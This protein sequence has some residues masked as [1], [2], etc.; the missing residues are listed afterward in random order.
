MNKATEELLNDLKKFRQLEDYLRVNQQELTQI[1]L[2][3]HLELLLRTCQ[4]SKAEVIARANLQESYGYQI[5]SG[6]KKPSRNK[7]LAVC[8]GL[9]L[10][11]EQTQ[12]LLM[13]ANVGALYP[14]IQRDSVILFALQHG[15]PLIACNQLLFDLNEPPI[16]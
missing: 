10:T 7:L 14:R 15:I 6:R 11:P 12:R 13:I 5:F 16:E 4:R 8:F 3:Q 1:S 9:G 2:K